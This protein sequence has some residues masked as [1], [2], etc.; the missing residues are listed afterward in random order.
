MRP[1]FGM[2]G[3]EFVTRINALGRKTRTP[4]RIDQNRGKGSHVTLFYG[5]RFTV[6]KDRR[7]ELPKGLLHNMLKQLGL[8]LDDI[9]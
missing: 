9:S 7:K 6:V 1:R 5:S 8:T 3:A 4:V 2:R